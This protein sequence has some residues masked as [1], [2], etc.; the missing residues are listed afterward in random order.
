MAPPLRL[1]GSPATAAASQKRL[2]VKGFVFQHVWHPRPEPQCVVRL[3]LG[4]VI[5]DKFQ[6]CRPDASE[7]DIESGQDLCGHAFAYARDA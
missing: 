4:S 3:S 6:D 7:L 1:F 2:H 5:G